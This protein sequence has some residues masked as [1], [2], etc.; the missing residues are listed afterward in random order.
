LHDWFATI[1]RWS[2]PVT[3][4]NE[5]L[6]AADRWTED[7]KTVFWVENQGVWLWAYEH[8]SDDPIVYD[9]EAE[10]D[11]PWRSSNVSLSAFMLQIAVFEAILGSPHGASSVWVAQP[12]L[13]QIL[14][15]MA[16][17]PGA[18]WHW[19]IDG[20]RFYAGNGTLASF[21]SNLDP[22]EQTE[23]LETFD[24]FFAATNVER[25]AY[26]RDIPGVRWDRPPT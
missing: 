4:Q 1:S 17:V 25:L 14:A 22:A 19:P 20:Y 15:P 26:L 10:D 7:G 18:I 9:R 5:V 21:G 12:Q 23:D 16:P 6:H 8:G 3:F 11:E 2:R 24:L 13:D